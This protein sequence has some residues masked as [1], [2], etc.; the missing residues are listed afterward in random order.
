MRDDLDVMSV[1]DVARRNG[2]SRQSVHTW[3]RRYADGGIHH[4]RRSVLDSKFGHRLGALNAPDC[5]IGGYAPPKDRCARTGS[6]ALDASE[7]VYD[8]CGV[9]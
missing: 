2:V 8:S 7:E 4:E 5:R 1:T 9:G 6:A 3:L